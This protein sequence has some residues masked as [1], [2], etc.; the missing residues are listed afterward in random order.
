MSKYFGTSTHNFFSTEGERRAALVMLSGIKTY[1]ST[2]WWGWSCLKSHQ[3]VFRVPWKYEDSSEMD[4]A[5]ST[6]SNFPVL[7]QN[8]PAWQQMFFCCF[9]KLYSENP[10]LPSCWTKTFD[11]CNHVE[12]HQNQGSIYNEKCC[13][14]SCHMLRGRS[15]K[16]INQRRRCSFHTYLLFTSKWSRES[17][18]SVHV[19]LLFS[20]PK[21]KAQMSP[22]LSQFKWPNQRSYVEF[23]PNYIPIR[24]HEVTGLLVVPE[25][26]RSFFMN[27][28]TTL[29]RV[30]CLSIH[31]FINCS[32]IP[33]VFLNLLM[34]ACLPRRSKDA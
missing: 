7:F 29:G 20:K 24:P 2:I 32:S 23:F 3:D 1:F 12:L 34:T 18:W 10:C 31:T 27:L 4:L 30:T 6:T 33:K 19:L 16:Y 8:A 14:V 22:T 15:A 28:D 21:S 9:Q 17:P 26:E 25:R 5:H 13:S 11:W